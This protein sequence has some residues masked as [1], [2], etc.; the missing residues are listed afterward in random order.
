[1]RK[2]PPHITDNAVRLILAGISQRIDDH[3]NRHRE[4]RAKGRNRTPSEN[5]EMTQINKAVQNLEKAWKQLA[6]P[7]HKAFNQNP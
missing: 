6:V 5:Q 1:M 7:I 2:I 3:L 4:L